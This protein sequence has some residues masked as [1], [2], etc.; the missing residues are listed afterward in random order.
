MTIVEHSIGEPR[1][2]RV[3]QETLNGK[4]WPRHNNTSNKGH[5]IRQ[6]YDANTSVIAQAE[7]GS[8]IGDIAE[9]LQKLQAG[10]LK[11]GWLIVFGCC[12]RAD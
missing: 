4:F 5:E 7:H 10:G 3:E 1:L 8:I 2:N 12:Q 9:A 11:T 6:I